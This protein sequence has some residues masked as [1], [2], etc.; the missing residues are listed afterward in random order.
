MPDAPHD[1]TH[2]PDAP[3]AAIRVAIVE[4]RPDVRRGLAELL[5]GAPGFD[6]VGAYESAEHALAS[7]ATVAADVVLMDI[8]LPGMSGI[9]ATREIRRRWPTHAGH[10]AHR[11]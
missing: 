7:L 1:E 4:D 6:A 5:R 10:D 11:L 9:D 2:P 8:E 3:C